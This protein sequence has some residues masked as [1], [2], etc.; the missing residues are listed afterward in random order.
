V[1]SPAFCIS[2]PFGT[3]FGIALWELSFQS[4]ARSVDWES[5]GSQPPRA[6][7]VQSSI[8]SR[9]LTASPL[10]A[11]D[12]W[13]FG[14]RLAVEICFSLCYRRCHGSGSVARGLETFESYR[15]SPFIFSDVLCRCR[16]AK[17]LS[18]QGSSLHE[19]WRYMPDFQEVGSGI[20]WL[21]NLLV[22]TTW[23]T[24][25]VAAAHRTRQLLFV[26]AS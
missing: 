9:C 13:T 18:Q 12:Q 26:Y 1:T 21:G 17:S 25:A 7:R 6:G 15:L 10:S 11:N 24:A 16:E 14:T 2:T 4:G 23:M 3:E 8:L 22:S 19:D 5:G 20:A